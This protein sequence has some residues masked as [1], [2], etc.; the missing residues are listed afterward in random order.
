MKKLLLAAGIA[1][2]AG[3]LIGVTLLLWHSGPLRVTSKSTGTGSAR[4]DP[5]AS[6]PV[7]TAKSASQDE[8]GSGLNLSGAEAGATGQS[9]DAVSPGSSA[10]RQSSST[11]TI[12]NRSYP[13]R[14]YQPM[15]LPN[16]PSANQPMVTNSR[17]DQ[18]WDVPAGNRQTTLAIIDTGFGLQHEE[19]ANRWY[20]NSGETGAALSE[21]AS[22]LNCTDRGLAVSASCNLVDD[23]GDDIVDNETGAAQYQ[24]ASQ[25]NCSGRNRPL[26]KDCNLID[27][28][29]NGYADD[30][31]GWDF[32]DGDNSPQAGDLNPAGDGTYHGTMAA[33]VAAATGNNGKGIAG[34]DWNTKIL[35]LQ[36]LDDNSYGDTLSVGRAIYYA[37]GQHADVIS[38]SLGSDEPDDYVEQAVTAAEAAGIVVVA[39]AGNSPCDCMVYPAHYPSVVAVGALDSS[40]TAASFS[41]WGNDLDIMA[42]G[43]GI[44]TTYWRTG[45]RTASYVSGAAGTSFAAPLVAGLMTRMLS[46]RSESPLQLIA[47]LTENTNRLSL[48]AATPRDPHYGFGALDA[49]RSERRMTTPRTLSQIYGFNPI[50]LGARGSGPGNPSEPAGV[51]TVHQCPEA[52]TQG[53]PVYELTKPEDA[54]FTISAAEAA[55]AR[56]SGYSQGTFTYACIQQPGDTAQYVRNISAFKEFR[57]LSDKTGL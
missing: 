44:T 47:A 21:A 11:V 24:N 3:V 41:S 5:T 53:T 38:I 42:P 30:V 19:F 32:V 6:V 18:A 10:G 1:G 28:D 57:N 9:S 4:G 55:A 14:R 26:A 46:Q 49:G 25:L 27:D 48:P 36:A 16:D 23:N 52:D 39:A 50:S 31:S 20:Q 43:T 45:N 34:A 54:F 29:G 56:K 40:N 17:L 35:P 22:R 37:I 7:A 2:C 12:D 15:L 8:N 51:Y 13:R 33:G